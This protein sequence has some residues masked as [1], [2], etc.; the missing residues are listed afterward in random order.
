MRRLLAVLALVTIATAVD[1]TVGADVPEVAPPSKRVVLISDS[2]GLGTRGIFPTYFPAD[3]SANVVGTPAMFVEQLQATYVDGGDPAWFGDHAVVA[4]GYNYPYWDPARFDRSIDSMVA[5]LRAKGVRHIH[6]VTLREVKPE[7]ISPAAWRQVQPYYWYFPTVNDHLER[8]L[9]RHP[10]LHLVDWAAVADRSGITYDAIHLNTAGANLYSGLVRESVDTVGLRVAAGSVTEISVPDP[11]ATAAVAVNLTSV[12]PRSAGFF[13]AFGCGGSV[14]VVSNHNHG[15]AEV[16]ASAAIV[17]VGP[18]GTICVASHDSSHVIVDTT[19]RFPIGAGIVAV[20]PNRLR[21]TR[22]DGPDP[23]PAGVA[24]RVPVTGVGGVPAD[25][26]AVALSVTAVGA[27][28]SGYVTVAGC[29]GPLPAT[30]N[31]NHGPSGA[32]P[33]LVVIAPGPTG[34]VCVVPSAPVEL[35]VDVFAAFESTA[36]IDLISPARALDTR[37]STGV[38]AGGTVVVDLA[39]AGV[40]PGASG[41]LLNLTATRTAGQGFLTAYPCDEPQPNASN[42][43]MSGRGDV[44][45]FA[46]VAPDDAGRVCVFS[47]VA[48]DLVVDVFGSLGSV[49]EGRA[50]TRILDTRTR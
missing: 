11:V 43:N 26:A 38:T 19:G 9:A 49:F 16:L 23:H 14:P 25:P 8:A 7:Y 36:D 44:A 13:T 27:G 24:L 18:D 5:A 22:Q 41:A 39:T 20:T 48:T 29:D 31:V 47:S 1:R 12:A 30:S 10:D 42:L 34:E 40:E 15:R 33:N 32:T 50:P 45:N 46:I 35:I 37:R 28:A 4:G 21:D 17:P 6:W 2:V 3:W